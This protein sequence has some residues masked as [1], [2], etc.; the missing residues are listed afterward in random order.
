MRSYLIEY[1]VNPFARFG[2]ENRYDIQNIHIPML[3]AFCRILFIIFDSRFG[4]FP[5]VDSLIL[6]RRIFSSQ[7]KYVEFFCA[8]F[9]ALSFFLLVFMQRKRCID[10][11]KMS[12]WF[13]ESSLHG[14][15]VFVCVCVCVC[16]CWCASLL[17][18]SHKSPLVQGLN[19]SKTN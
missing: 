9:V 18:L 11:L 8:F 10:Q 5:S 6:F 12:C 2:L 7:W 14:L 16:G 15:H 4:V 19:L 17:F 3:S 13:S 1:Y